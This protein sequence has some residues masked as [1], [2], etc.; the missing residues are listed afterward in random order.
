M[1][2]DKNY[3]YSNLTF[4]EIGIDSCSHA[5][6]IFCNELEVGFNFFDHVASQFRENIVIVITINVDNVIPLTNE[7]WWMSP[8]NNQLG[9]MKSEEVLTQLSLI[10]FNQKKEKKNAI[11]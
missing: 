5:R 6:E 11:D 2:D 3:S 7:D 9:G 10:D 1:I 8:G 4:K